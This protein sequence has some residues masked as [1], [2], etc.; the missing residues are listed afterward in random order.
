MR[1]RLLF[2]N[3]YSKVDTYFLK[4]NLTVLIPFGILI[5]V[6]IVFLVVRNQKD[7]SKLEDKLNNDYHKSKDEE[8]D[9]ETDEVM[10]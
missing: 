10:K 1:N 5:I 8:G 2:C 3:W 7:K 4:M 9:I 6:L